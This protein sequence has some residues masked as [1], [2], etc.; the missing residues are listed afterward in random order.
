VI[1]LLEIIVDSRIHGGLY[2]FHL[3]ARKA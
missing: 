2:E 3:A 1:D